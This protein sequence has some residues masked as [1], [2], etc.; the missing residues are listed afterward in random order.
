MLLDYDDVHDVSDKEIEGDMKGKEKVGKD[1]RKPFKEVLKCPLT[2]RIVEFSS[3]GH[4]MPANA[5]IYNGIS[6]PEDHVGWFIGMGN[7]GE[8][9]MPVWCRMFQ[10]ALEGKVRAWFNNLSSSSIDN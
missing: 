7:Q 9:P 10:Q 8:W 2:R 3:R 1:L 6:N 4:I 5:K